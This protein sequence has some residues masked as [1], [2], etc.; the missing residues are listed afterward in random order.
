MRVVKNI[1]WLIFI[2]VPNALVLWVYGIICC[3]TLLFIP[4]GIK[5]FNL[6][7]R[8][9]LPMEADV[10]MNIEKHP[11][12]NVLWASFPGALIAADLI[13]MGVLFSVTLIGI[14]IALSAFRLVKL[15]FF[16][17]GAKIEEW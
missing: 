9:I 15:M 13:V 16:P 6:A 2:G 14:P 10:D 5:A 7:K 3:A 12:M 11:V 17:F 4:F 1:F 8:V